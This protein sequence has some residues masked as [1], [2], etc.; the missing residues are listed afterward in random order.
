MGFAFRNT[1][2]L[3]IITSTTYEQGNQLPPMQAGQRIKVTFELD[4]ILAPGDYALVLNFEDRTLAMPH[5]YDFIEN[6]LIFK[7]VS[8]F[9]I[10][11]QVL[12]L[13][14]QHISADL[15][16]PEVHGG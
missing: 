3:D 9:P 8:Q 12:P 4:N 15:G 7:T 16:L 1:K 13:V 10:Y 6:A 2:G 5:Y 14:H 11:S